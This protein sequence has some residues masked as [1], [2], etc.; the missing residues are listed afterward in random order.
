MS[1]CDLLN[2]IWVFVPVNVWWLSGKNFK[3]RYVWSWPVAS[4]NGRYLEA[5]AA[6]QIGV[7]ITSKFGG[8]GQPRDLTRFCRPRRSAIRHVESALYVRFSRLEPISSA[9]NQCVPV[10]TVT[11]ILALTEPY[12]TSI[13]V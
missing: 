13:L 11:L 10:G 7:F 4:R 9:H 2:M 5:R 6:G 8:P 12:C 3:A 1:C